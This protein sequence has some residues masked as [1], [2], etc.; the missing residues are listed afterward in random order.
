MKE[1]RKRKKKKPQG[2]NIMSAYATQG[3]HK[4][5]FPFDLFYNNT[6]ICICLL[7]NLYNVTQIGAIIN[8]YVQT[9]LIF[10]YF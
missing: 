9:L 7:N 3:G 1:K 5:D 6:F 2:K 4:Q 10:S 8:S